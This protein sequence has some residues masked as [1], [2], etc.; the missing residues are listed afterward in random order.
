MNYWNILDECSRV[1]KERW[2]SYA[3]PDENFARWANIHK[4]LFWDTYTP[5]QLSEI[6]ISMKLSREA[7]KYKRDNT[8]DVINYLAIR[9]HFISNN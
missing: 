3:W 1:A 5:Q 9:E 8:I 2:E 7:N 6:M 4:A